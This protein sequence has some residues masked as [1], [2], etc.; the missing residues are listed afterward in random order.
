MTNS[1]GKLPI[2]DFTK[3]ASY[4]LLDIEKNNKIDN[5][6]DVILPGDVEFQDQ[7]PL[8]TIDGNKL[9]LS[10]GNGTVKLVRTGDRM[11]DILTGHQ[12]IVQWASVYDNGQ[13][14]LTS[15]FDNTTKVW[16]Y[17]APSTVEMA[18]LLPR[19]TDQDFKKYGVSQSK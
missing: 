4:F 6:N 3:A 14:I 5:L 16:R 8:V 19:L 2:R 9:L 10:Q 12:R 18:N 1:S 13:F 7:I 11:V 15:A 17:L